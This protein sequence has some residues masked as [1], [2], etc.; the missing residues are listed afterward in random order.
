MAMPST[1]RVLKLNAQLSYEK[2]QD[3]QKAIRELVA[4][5]PEAIAPLV[6]ALF[7]EEDDVERR[8]VNAARALA[9]LASPASCERA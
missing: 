2:D 9:S 1:S 7:C 5:G 6:D 3:Q 4:L 8:S